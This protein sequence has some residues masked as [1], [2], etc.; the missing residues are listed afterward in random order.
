MGKVTLASTEPV[1][2]RPLQRVTV[3]R[4]SIARNK[5]EKSVVNPADT[6]IVT[7]TGPPGVKL[8]SVTS[9]TVADG[10]PPKRFLRAKAF[11][12]NVMPKPGGV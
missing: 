6:F 12:L 7:D 2:S 11:E 9:I 1:P 5:N 8:P 3:G 4:A 10:S